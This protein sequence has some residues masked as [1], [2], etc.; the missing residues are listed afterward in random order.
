MFNFSGTGFSDFSG[1]GLFLELL[2][3]EVSNKHYMDIAE[4]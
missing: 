1:I 2:Q 4:F 3:D